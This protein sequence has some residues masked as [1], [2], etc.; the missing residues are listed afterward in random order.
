MKLKLAKAMDIDQR[1]KFLLEGKVLNI[2]WFLAWPVLIQML[3]HLLVQ[4][5]DMKMVGTLG[6]GAVASM[7]MAMQL[8]MMLSVGAMGISTGVTAAVSL[9]YGKNDGQSTI[10]AAAQAVI[11]ALTLSGVVMILV[12]LSA[13]MLLQWMGAEEAV[14]LLAGRYMKVFAAGILFLIGRFVLWAVFQGIGDNRTP[15]KLDILTNVLNVA[16][17]YIF[18]FGVGPVPAFGVIGAAMGTILAHGVGISLAFYLVRRKAFFKVPTLRELLQFNRSI[19]GMV[20]RIGAPAALQMLMQIGA[21]T[22][23]LALV[24]RSAGSTYA[25]SGY[26]VGLLIFQYAI[27]PA[28]AVGHAA[29]TLVGVNLGASNN[30][31]A[32]HSGWSCAKAGALLI[33]FLSVFIYLNAS[34]LIG[35]FVDDPLVIEAA[36]PLVRTLAV[37]EPLHA[38]GL[39]L[40]RVFYVA[41]ETKTPFTISLLSWVII[42]LSLAWFLAFYV[43]LQGPGIWYAIAISQVL[44]AVLMIWRYLRGVGFNLSESDNLSSGVGPVNAN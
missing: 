10:A 31:R 13:G 23:I 43:G 20:L 4:T 3:M 29:S 9:Y 21:N 22:L 39:I 2:V 32:H 12:Y 37:V 11:M 40:A 16:G 27:F 35:F 25:V 15:L 41:G 7:G 1:R 14:R 36:V 19:M 38:M 8:L 42:R 5:V 44:A 28:A 6:A 30:R 24:A 26:S 18:I 17:N 34:R 33:A